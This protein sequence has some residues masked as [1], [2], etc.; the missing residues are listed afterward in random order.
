MVVEHNPENNTE[1][2]SRIVATVCSLREATSAFRKNGER[3]ALIP[4]MGALH[5]G[6]L[7]LIEV[8][9]KISDRIVV[10]IFINPTQFSVSE[11][12][13]SYPRRTK[14]DLDILNSKKV[15]LVFMPRVNEMYGADFSTSV[16]VAGP[17]IGLE[18][19][20]RPHFFN[21]VAT[22]VTKLLLQCQ[23]D[24]AV[25]GEKDYQQL[26]VIR[27]L[28]VDLNIACQVLGVPTVR[29][30]D[31]LACSS[32]NLYLN[33]HQRRIAPELYKNLQETAHQIRAG[34]NLPSAIHMCRQRLS[35]A[36]FDNI[37]Y[38]DVCDPV[39]LRSISKY[40]HGARLLGAVWLGKTRLIDNLE[41]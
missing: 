32:R 39:S 26:Q 22:V 40:K 3:V 1:V 18:G 23:P 11:D 21:G 28:V 20:S 31:G 24:T 38:L 37:D 10:S 4:T 14:E 27:R 9:R 33:P 15:D 2:K 16:I 7:T 12:L 35:D 34:E 13:E 5:S 17:S 29:E 6:H 19:D 30:S 8:A 25:F 36:E 41:V